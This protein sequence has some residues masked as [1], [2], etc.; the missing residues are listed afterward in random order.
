LVAETNREK[1]FPGLDIFVNSNLK[2][3]DNLAMPDGNNMVKQVSVFPLGIS[4]IMWGQTRDGI[5]RELGGNQPVL[6]RAGGIDMPVRFDINNN[7][8]F[9]S[10]SRFRGLYR[11]HRLNFS[12][13][14]LGLLVKAERDD[15]VA[16]NRSPGQ[17]QPD[18]EQNCH[19]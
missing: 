3:N 18:Q 19:F 8:G 13:L 1:V 7:G 11:K 6:V 17:Y 12:Q 16:D 9:I 14:L 2:R 4:E 10:F 15:I 5:I